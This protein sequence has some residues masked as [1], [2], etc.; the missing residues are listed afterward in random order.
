MFRKNNFLENIFRRLV[1]TKK[2]RK[3]KMQLSPE[4]GNVRS[5]LP[6]SGEHVWP[7]LGHFGQIRS[8]SDHGQILPEFGPPAFGDGGRMSPNSGAD[9]ISEAG[10]CRI[11]V[12]PG[13]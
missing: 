3:V 5:P 7:D 13:F 4:S 11:P 10:C 8:A 12:P 1:R 2:L 6:D 9:I